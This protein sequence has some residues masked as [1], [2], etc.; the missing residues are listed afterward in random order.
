MNLSEDLCYY[1][2]NKENRKIQYASKNSIQ[3]NSKDLHTSE[4]VF[5]IKFA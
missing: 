4:N 3:S 1:M 5:K 2:Q